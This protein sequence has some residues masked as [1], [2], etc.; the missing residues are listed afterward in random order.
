MTWGRH[1][2][3]DWMTWG[4][5]PPSD[6]MTWGRY[7]PSDWMT[8]GKYPP[9]NWMTWGKYPPNPLGETGWE[10]RGTT[11]GEHP[12]KAAW[13][14][15]AGGTGARRRDLARQSVD[16]PCQRADVLRSH[17]V[18]SRLLHEPTTQAV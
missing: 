6:W 4:K 16:E 3:S 1:P 12:R 17:P 9:N 2:P 5:Y 8:W 15:D 18:L 13:E 14:L 11:G 7:P 10:T